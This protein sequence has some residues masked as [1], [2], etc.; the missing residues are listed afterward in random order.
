MSGR[1]L[2]VVMVD[3]HAE[4]ERGGA[5]Q[6]ARLASTLAE[7]GHRVT[8]LFD[9]AASGEAKAGPEWQRMAKAGVT[10]LRRPLRSIAAMRRF[11]SELRALGPDIV[12]THKNGA[13][14]FVA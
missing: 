10:I 7:R 12:H 13:L 11:G 1:P 6:C 9:V 4:I 5:I 8:C 14:Y 3:S 2:T